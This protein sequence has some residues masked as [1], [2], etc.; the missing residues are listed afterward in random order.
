MGLMQNILDTI[1]ALRLLGLTTDDC[2]D[3]GHDS[4]VL[5]FGDVQVTFMPSE[6][7]ILPMITRT[8]QSEV[9]EVERGLSRFPSVRAEAIFNQLKAI[10]S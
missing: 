10:R 9:V 8:G 4:F 5:H 3:L 1:E 7:E 2:V 6:L